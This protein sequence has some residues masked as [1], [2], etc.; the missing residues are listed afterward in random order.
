MLKLPNGELLAKELM[1]LSRFERRNISQNLFEV[2]RKYENQPDF[3][4]RRFL[5]YNGV[6]FLYIYYPINQSQKEIDLILKLAPQIY[7]YKYNCEMVVLLVASRGMKQ[8]KFGLF[9]S[10]DVSDEAKEYLENL[11]K[12]LGWFTNEEII[13]KNHREYPE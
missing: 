10:T 9:K 2:V 3:L 13:N 6:G 7:A 12:K 1:T 8:W 4:A 5:K 11:I